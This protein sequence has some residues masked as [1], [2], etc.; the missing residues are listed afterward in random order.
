MIEITETISL[1]R[2]TNFIDRGKMIDS[3][4]PIDRDERNRSRK[5]NGRKKVLS[6]R[7]EMIPEG[8]TR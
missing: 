4:G 2:E 8:P 1:E 3:L 7:L 5:R 6:I